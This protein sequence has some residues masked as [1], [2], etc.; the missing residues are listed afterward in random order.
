M[1]I[2]LAVLVGGAVV[3]ALGVNLMVLLAWMW[4]RR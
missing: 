4:G 2:I 1:D 3:L